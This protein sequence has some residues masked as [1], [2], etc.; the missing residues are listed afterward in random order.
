[1]NSFIVQKMCFLYGEW[2]NKNITTWMKTPLRV[3]NFHI[4]LNIN[5]LDRNTD[6]QIDRQIIKDSVKVK[7]YYKN[8]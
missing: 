6:R 3:F 2:L 5:D 4:V 8:K 1:M 7:T